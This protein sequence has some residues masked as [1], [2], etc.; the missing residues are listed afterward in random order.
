VR[1]SALVLLLFAIAGC[2]SGGGSEFGDV[3]LVLPAK[4]SANDLGA[5]FASA[6]GYD[7]AEGVTLQLQRGGS[8]DFRVVAQPTSNCVAVMAVVRPAKLVLC[9]DPFIL[10]DQRAE[11]VSVVRAL[12][13]GYT[14]AQLE[15]DE[16]VAAMAQV[17]PKLSAARLSAELDTAAATWT[18]GAP[19]FG[20]LAP[21]RYRDPSVA[22]DARKGY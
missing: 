20:Q 16:A 4:P 9:V 12:S 18:E 19:Y 7:E 8:A 1:F 2:G 21:G 15:P 3:K 5:Y 14:Q 10:H 17:V 6:R 11:V 13:R 22:A